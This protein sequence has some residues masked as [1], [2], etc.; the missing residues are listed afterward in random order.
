MVPFAYVYPKIWIGR[1]GS[2]RSDRGGSIKETRRLKSISSDFTRN[3]HVIASCFQLAQDTA[4]DGSRR[5]SDCTTGF[6][7]AIWCGERL[8]RTWLVLWRSAT[9]HAAWPTRESIRH[10]HHFNQTWDLMI[11]EFSWDKCCRGFRPT[12]LFKLLIFALCAFKNLGWHYE[13]AC[14]SCKE[15]SLM[16]IHQKD[17]YRFLV[18]KM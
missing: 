7:H 11:W 9:H 1:A 3:K 12:G 13:M 4:P 18:I 17:D 14:S 2:C 5:Y 8:R 6:P 10:T 15:R 16:Q